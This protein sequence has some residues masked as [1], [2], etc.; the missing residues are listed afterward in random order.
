MDPISILVIALVI[1]YAGTDLLYAV[2]GQPNPNHETKA[3]ALSTRAQV[4]AQKWQLRDKQSQAR[5]ERAQA[6]AGRPTSPARRYA[7]VLK[8][9]AFDDLAER[10]TRKREAR[11]AKAAARVAGDEPRNAATVYLSNR[12]NEAKRGIHNYWERKWKEADEKRR[13]KATRPR[14]GQ[15]TVPG[16]V[17]PNAQN[18]GDDLDGAEAPKA[19]PCPNCA[20]P[21]HVPGTE[22]LRCQGAREQSSIITIPKDAYTDCPNPDCEGTLRPTGLTHLDE[23]DGSAMANL[24]CDRKCGISSSHNWTPT[25]AE[26]EKYFGHPF[27]EDDEDGPAPV[28]ASYKEYTDSHEP[29]EH[30]IGTIPVANMTD[31]MFAYYQKHKASNGTATPTPEG[32]NTMSNTAIEVIGLSD[33]IAN[34]NGSAINAEAAASGIE[35][36]VAGLV[37]GGTSGPALS[38]FAA[39]QEHFNAAADR[40]RSAAGHLQQQTVVKEA[41]AA[42][43]GHAGSKEFVTAE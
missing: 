38:D 41:Y 20:G 36:T 1:K 16:E 11:K 23:G 35:L 17:V 5:L 8:D 22:C 40:L 2:R 21:T 12:K 32:T 39:A 7:Q 29:G 14:P 26:Y 42:T 37:N 9:D 30:K 6:K 4:R 43:G 18:D 24:V 3:N 33:A 25:D 13:A 28:G 34:A 19:D 15:D 27:G 31:E 10:H